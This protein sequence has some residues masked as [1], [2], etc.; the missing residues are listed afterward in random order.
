MYVNLKYSTVYYY[1]V[2]IQDFGSIEKT[3]IKTL[4][5]K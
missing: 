4:L 2:Y 1:G 5:N 3:F